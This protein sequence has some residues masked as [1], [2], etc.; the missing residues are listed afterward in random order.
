MLFILIAI[1]CL[2]FLALY[3]IRSGIFYNVNIRTG[4][5]PFGKVL[6]GCLFSLVQVLISYH[7]YNP[8]HLNINFQIAYK[9]YIGSYFNVGSALK[10]LDSFKL[11]NKLKRL[12]IYYD[13]PNKMKKGKHRYIV[14][15]V[16]NQNESE[17]VDY[18][19]QST[20]EQNGFKIVSFPEIKNGIITEFPIRTNLSP[21]VS[22]CKVY[23][24]F[25]KYFQ[26]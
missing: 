13:D 6:I 15:V 17:S 18:E 14:G 10:E 20:L 9:F 22:I 25:G 7:Q 8:L 1:V 3:L 11:K 19:A 16:L 24:K 2:L 4:H 12:A 23:P 21:L 26:V 5:P